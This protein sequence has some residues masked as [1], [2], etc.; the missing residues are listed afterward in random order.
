VL[1]WLDAADAALDEADALQARVPDLVEVRRVVRAQRGRARDAC[2][3][4]VANGG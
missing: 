1:A 4:G 2:P 3:G